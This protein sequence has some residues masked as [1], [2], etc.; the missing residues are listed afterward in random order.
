MTDVVVIGGGTMGSAAAW[1]LARRGVDVTLLEQFQPRHDNGASHGSS[2]IFRLAYL[3]DA[4]VRLAQRALELWRLLEAES[5]REVLTLTG[6]VDHGPEKPLRALHATLQAAGA[7][8]EFLDPTDAAERWPGLRF[9]TAVL[10]HRDAGRVHADDAVVAF[11]EAAANNGADVRHGV[12]V[13]AINERTDGLTVT[14][15]AGEELRAT[16]VVLGAGAWTPLLFPDLAASLRT[17]QEQPAHFPPIDPTT[18][19]PSFIHHPGAGLSTAG[20]TASGIY[21]LGSVDGVKVGFHAIGPVTDPDRRDRAPDPAVLRD[22]RAYARD[23]LPGVDADAGVPVTCLYTLTPDQRFVVD[24][25]GRHTVLAGFSG[26]GFKFSPAIGELAAQLTLD[27][28]RTAPQ[29][30]IDRFAALTVGRA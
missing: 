25:V 13:A 7:Q 10:F 20:D 9:D 30:A 18:E 21:G 26:H 22:L 17:T 29:F 16:S 23:W 2:R 15:T 11:Q 28:L 14:T 24:R 19:W 5:G 6:A 8:S 12:R 4:H 1:Q 27:G 3:D